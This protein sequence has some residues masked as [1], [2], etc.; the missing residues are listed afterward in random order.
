MRKSRYYLHMDMRSTKIIKLELTAMHRVTHQMV[1]SGKIVWNLTDYA[2]WEIPP[3][4]R[5]AG[6]LQK[7]KSKSEIIEEKT[8]Q[9]ASDSDEDIYQKKMLAKQQKCAEMKRLNLNDAHLRHDG[10]DTD[11]ILDCYEAYL[12]GM[13]VDLQSLVPDP[14]AI[15]KECLE[16]WNCP[17]IRS[18]IALYYLRNYAYWRT[19]AHDTQC[20][21]ERAFKLA[22]AIMSRNRNKLKG[23]LVT[24]IYDVAAD[25]KLRNKEFH[26]LNAEWMSHEDRINNRGEEGL[27][28]FG[29]A[30]D[31]T[32]H[33]STQPV[34]QSNTKVKKYSKKKPKSPTKTNLSQKKYR[35]RSNRPRKRVS[36]MKRL[37]S[38]MRS[39]SVT[40][41]PG[42]SAGVDYTSAP[43]LGAKL[44][45]SM[46]HHPDLTQWKIGRNCSDEYDNQNLNVGI[47]Q[48]SNDDVHE[49]N[50]RMSE[51][52][53]EIHTDEGQEQKQLA[54]PGPYPS[55]SEFLGNNSEQ[56]SEHANLSQDPHPTPTH[57]A[58]SE[59]PSPTAALTDQE[60]DRD[61]TEELSDSES[62]K[63]N[64]PAPATGIPPA[65]KKSK[66]Q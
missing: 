53:N 25:I 3:E 62:D 49:I 11:A 23:T 48:D 37:L 22:Q 21:T 52:E 31:L 40:P 17:Q 59:S 47:A 27:D 28:Y 14:L 64:D 1:A 20:L 7:K 16:F 26:E 44:P 66:R 41:S 32:N 51:D 39:M 24:Q 29:S 45:P 5:G 18:E 61:G 34:T 35:K 50:D 46:D 60:N 65:K 63:E 36:G 58:K 10:I 19:C 30:L 8:E 4:F 57:S 33:E 56:G 15:Q 43:E 6:L 9:N 54:T 55:T 12:T 13:N 2:L 38:E 42:K